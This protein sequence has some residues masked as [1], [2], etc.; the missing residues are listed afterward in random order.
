MEG[1][2]PAGI[3]PLP[4]GANEFEGGLASTGDVS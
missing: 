4:P 3:R 2:V 1:G